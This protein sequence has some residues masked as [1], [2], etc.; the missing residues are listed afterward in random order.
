MTMPS[1]RV[2][3]GTW[4]LKKRD[5]PN[6]NA[7]VVG[8]IFLL[9]AAVWGLK[10]FDEQGHGLIPVFWAT[11]AAYALFA[12]LRRL[13]AGVDVNDRSV[14]SVRRYSSREIEWTQVDSFES[15]KGNRVGAQLKNGEWV[16]L[17]TFFRHSPKA[18][19]LVETLNRLRTEYAA[20]GG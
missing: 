18:E 7:R 12:A 8:L 4:L 20:G 15:R 11:L 13:R 3:I 19:E 5:L 17:Q 14:W 10:A 9:F 6:R 1:H 16:P 2:R